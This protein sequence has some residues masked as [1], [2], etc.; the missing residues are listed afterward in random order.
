MFALILTPT[1]SHPHIQLQ[2]EDDEVHATLDQAAH[3]VSFTENPENFDTLET[4]TLL[5]TQLREAI[6]LERTLG[7]FN[8]ELAGDPR[9]IERVSVHVY[10]GL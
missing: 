8:K 2:I 6:S 1:P 7:A 4:L 10:R 9:Y 3:M 5:D